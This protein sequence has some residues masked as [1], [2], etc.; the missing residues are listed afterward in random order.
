MNARINAL[1]L[2]LSQG[3]NPQRRTPKLEESSPDHLLSVS[4]DHTPL[5]DDYEFGTL[6]DDDREE[7]VEA[8][9]AQGHAPQPAA[10]AA[11][12]PQ[13]IAPTPAGQKTLGRMAS[14]LLADA[15][16]DHERTPSSKVPVDFRALLVQ[17]RDMLKLVRKSGCGEIA[18]FLTVF[19]ALATEKK[20]D[21]KRFAQ[22]VMQQ[23][24][25]HGSVL[26]ARALKGREP[27]EL[28][29][30]DRRENFEEPPAGYEANNSNLGY[31]EQDVENALVEVN[32]WLGTLCD[33][34]PRSDDDGSEREYLGLTDGLE[35]ISKVVDLTDGTRRYDPVHSV[36]EALEIQLMKNRA[37]LR[38]KQQRDVEAKAAQFDALRRMIEPRSPV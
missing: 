34:L 27:D 29:E 4:N 22:R 24:L 33:L 19:Q 7:M 6:R 21:A 38:L 15:I 20:V 35:Y 17:W 28:V 25:W 37:S 5:P 12:T 1:A 32:G 8:A 16:S 26:Y 10:H 9:E 14:K 11:A 13:F 18:A 31:T 3:I 23:A 2:A 30:G 36:T